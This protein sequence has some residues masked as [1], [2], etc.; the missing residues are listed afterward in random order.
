MCA[1]TP[2]SICSSAQEMQQQAQPTRQRLQFS[3][4]GT[5]PVALTS[6]TLQTILLFNTRFYLAQVMLP[7]VILV[8]FARLDFSARSDCT[9][10]T[11][12]GFGGSEFGCTCITP[13]NS[14]A[15]TYARALSFIRGQ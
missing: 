9:Y 8:D 15:G 3:D 13:Q 6:K 12:L 14:Q 11:A 5:T 7:F 4:N 1:L 10:N 2:E